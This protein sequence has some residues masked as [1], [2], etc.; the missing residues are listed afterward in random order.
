MDVRYLTISAI[1]GAILAIAV[2]AVLA[3]YFSGKS[4]KE[5]QQALQKMQDEVNS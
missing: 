4:A 2:V 3:F 1:A 5:K